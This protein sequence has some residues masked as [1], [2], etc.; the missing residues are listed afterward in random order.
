LKYIG[1]D[2]YLNTYLATGGDL[3]AAIISGIMHEY[4]SLKLSFAIM[5]GLSLSGA[6]VYIFYETTNTMTIAIIILFAK[7]GLGG[8]F[9]LCFLANS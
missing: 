7:F 3:I 1:G 5:F 4:M 9:N 8:T 2:I 6:V